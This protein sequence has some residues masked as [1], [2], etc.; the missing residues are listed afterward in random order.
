MQLT[1]CGEAVASRPWLKQRGVGPTNPEVWWAGRSAHQLCELH[2]KVPLAMHSAALTRAKIH[3]W[4]NTEGERGCYSMK[5]SLASYLL[6][7][8]AV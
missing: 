3:I 5:P 7:L 8:P 4:V 1:C 6:T 2:L